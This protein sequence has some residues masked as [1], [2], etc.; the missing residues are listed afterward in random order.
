YRAYD[1][2][3]G[4]WLSEDPIFEA[5]GLNLYGY[6]GN[7]PTDAWDTLGL[8]PTVVTDAEVAKLKEKFGPEYNAELGKLNKCETGRN[9][10]KFLARDDVKINHMISGRSSATGGTINLVRQSGYGT[11]AHEAQHISEHLTGRTDAFGETSYPEDREWSDR[12][13]AGDYAAEYRACRI[14][15]QVRKE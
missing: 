3:L 2:G 10:L 1:P 14:E 11:I 8:D 12:T 9:I 6:V 7:A 5:G 4:R 15:N 13:A